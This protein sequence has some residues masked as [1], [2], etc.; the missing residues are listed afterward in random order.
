MQCSAY[1]RKA[2][3]ITHIHLFLHIAIPETLKARTWP[4]LFD[5][6]IIITPISYPNAGLLGHPVITGIYIVK[7]Y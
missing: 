7:I 6:L 5:Q 3:C 4:R 2:L 1:P